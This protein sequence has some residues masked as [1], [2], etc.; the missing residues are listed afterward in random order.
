VWN[1][2]TLAIFFFWLEKQLE[3]QNEMAIVRSFQTFDL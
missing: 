3:K 2:L 1:E